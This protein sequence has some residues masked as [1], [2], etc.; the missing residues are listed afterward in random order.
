MKVQLLWNSIRKIDSRRK[1]GNSY[2]INKGNRFSSYDV[3]TLKLKEIWDGI[4]LHQDFWVTGKYFKTGY[5]C[6]EQIC[7]YNCVF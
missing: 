4:H 6:V 3:G 1:M 7:I 2:I 5:F